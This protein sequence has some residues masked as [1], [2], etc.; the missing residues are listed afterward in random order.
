MNDFSNRANVR[1]YRI[2]TASPALLVH[3]VSLLIL[4]GKAY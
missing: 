1:Y 4:I 3:I 2:D